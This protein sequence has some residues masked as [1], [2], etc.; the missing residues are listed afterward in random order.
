MILFNKITMSKKNLIKKKEFMIAFSE[1]MNIITYVDQFNVLG[2]D[3]FIN[4]DNTS[5]ILYATILSKFMITITDE[6]YIYFKEYQ[7]RIFNLIENLRKLTPTF[8]SLVFEYLEK[9]NPYLPDIIIML[10][11]MPRT[12]NYLSKKMYNNKYKEYI[13]KYNHKL[14][15]I[16]E[17]RI[18]KNF[19]IE[20]LTKNNNVPVHCIDYIWFYMNALSLEFTFYNS[21]NNSYIGF[22]ISDHTDVKNEFYV[23]FGF[24]M[25]YMLEMNLGQ[26]A[27]ENDPNQK[28]SF[29]NFL[30]NFVTN[31]IL[32]EKMLTSKTKHNYKSQIL[33]IIENPSKYFGDILTI[34]PPDIISLFKK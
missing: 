31:S 27:Y 9:I 7:E 6:E 19:C 12:A 22:K 26:I 28:G 14:I 23:D 5:L 16:I 1:K 17:H 24:N 18:M 13:N 34:V 11:C 30:K 3:E 29:R 21:D 32:V 10:W 25:E 4:C 8:I 33:K 2:I 15:R 20:T